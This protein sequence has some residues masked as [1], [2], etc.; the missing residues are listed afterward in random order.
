MGR[1][2]VGLCFFASVCVCVH[3]CVHGKMKAAWRAGEER[4]EMRTGKER[5]WQNK[6]TTLRPTVSLKSGKRE[7]L[8]FLL[9]AA[10]RPLLFLSL[11]L[12]DILKQFLKP[13]AVWLQSPCCKSVP[14][15]LF[16]SQP[17]FCDPSP[18]GNTGPTN[19]PLTQA[20]RA[21]RS[22]QLHSHKVDCSC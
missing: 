3:A 11:F 8:L 21:H 20:C 2:I 22:N 15:G 7:S 5:E 4:M 17:A 16:S 19:S 1:G 9:L 12:A 18:T 13:L 6:N 10:Q 14:R